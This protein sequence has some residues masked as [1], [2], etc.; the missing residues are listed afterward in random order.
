MSCEKTKYAWR[1]LDS[2]S[3]YENVW[4]RVVSRCEEPCGGARVTY[5]S[6]KRAVV[7]LACAPVL[8]DSCSVIEDA[9]LGTI[10]PLSHIHLV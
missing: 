7:R 9:W 3:R 10:T 5:I 2:G 4:S 8:K 1:L 6:A